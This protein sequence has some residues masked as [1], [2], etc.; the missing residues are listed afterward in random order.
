MSERL[1]RNIEQDV[2]AH[3][4]SPTPEQEPKHAEKKTDIKSETLNIEKTR[5]RIGEIHKP[6]ADQ[7]DESAQSASKIINVPLP[8]LAPI[9]DTITKTW[10]SIR[11]NLSPSERRYSKIIHNPV[12]SSIS[13]FTA[14]TL[15]RPYAI[16]SGGIVALIGSGLY[17]YYTR[18]LGY[19]YNFFVPILLFLSGLVV[20]IAVELIYKFT[21]GHR[22]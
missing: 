13:E 3:E 12:V 18:H 9:I 21:Y 4:A 20:G 1:P 15:A 10:S 11:R 16:L 5:E 14:K 19:K 17:M 22:K 8:D 6:K 2:Q 7:L